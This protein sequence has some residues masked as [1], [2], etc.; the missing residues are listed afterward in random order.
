[1]AEGGSITVRYLMRSGRAYANKDDAEAALCDLVE[2]GFCQME[3]VP[4]GPTGGQPSMRYRLIDR[5]DVDNT[6]A[7]GPENGGIVNVDDVAGA[8][9]DDYGEL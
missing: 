8:I 2:A 5:V 1:L 6:P 9:D 7:G 4:I 3:P